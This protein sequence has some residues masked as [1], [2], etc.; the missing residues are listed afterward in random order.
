MKKIAITLIALMVISV[1]ILS[2][3]NET[4]L[5]DEKK[6]EKKQEKYSEFVEWVDDTNNW[7]DSKYLQIADSIQEE[8]WDDAL[9]YCNQVRNNLDGYI[10]EGRDFYVLGILDL[11]RDEFVDSLTLLDDAYIHYEYAVENWEIGFDTSGT[12]HWNMADEYQIQANNHKL[13]CSK[14][15]SDWYED[16]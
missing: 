14:Y 5:N 6:E 12:Q 2:G 8:N 7:I 10:S 13:N 9:Y 4:D 11:A 16:S 15:I 1:G 3:C